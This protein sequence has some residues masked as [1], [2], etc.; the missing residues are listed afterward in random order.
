MNRL[1]GGSRPAT[2]PYD[3]WS[4]MRARLLTPTASTPTRS[5]RPGTNSSARLAGRRRA[6]R[7]RCPRPNAMTLA[8]VGAGRAPV[9]RPDR[10]AARPL[11][12]DAAFVFF[13]NHTSAQGPRAAGRAL[14]RSAAL[15]L[16]VAACCTARSHVRGTG[17][18]WSLRPRPPRSTSGP[19][20]GGRGSGPGRQPPVPAG[21]L[22]D[23]LELDDGAGPNWHAALRRTGRRSGRRAGAAVL[24]RVAWSVP[25]P[26]WS[27]GRAA[28]TGCTTGCVSSSTTTIAAGRSVASPPEPW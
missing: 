27:S 13:S 14:R 11:D 23:R 2:E 24:G 26:R 21:R 20:R 4:R 3:D 12:R 16:L 17:R 1:P 10:A 9:E 15:V 28:A 8:T 5:T 22:P 19:G 18:A 25:E 6:G 7:R